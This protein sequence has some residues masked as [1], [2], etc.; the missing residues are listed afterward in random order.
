MSRMLQSKK[1]PGSNLAW[2]RSVW[3]TC[4]LHLRFFTATLASSHRPKTYM[5]GQLV[6]LNG[7]SE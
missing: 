4:F 7:P 3:S 6:I 1:V 2:G 5:L